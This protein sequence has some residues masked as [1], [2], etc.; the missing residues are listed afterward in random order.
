MTIL[1]GKA[2]WLVAF[3]LFAGQ[4][5]AQ[6]QTSNLAF[7]VANM[8]EDL[9][10]L[11]EAIRSMRVELDNMRRE[12]GQLREQVSG[13]ETRIGNSMGQL[14]TIGQVNEAV[15]KAVTALELRDER[16]KNEI[17]LKV[18]QEITEFANSVK[19]SIGGM[20]EASAK[21]DPTLRKSFPK[22]FPD[23]GTPYVVRAGDTLSSIAKTFGSSVDWIQ[24]ANKIA[25]PRHLQA[26]RTLFIPHN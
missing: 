7:Q 22:N 15:A 20:P 12:N 10:I 16:M 4:G 13:Y 14:A 9:R 19:K 23:T 11:D 24:N 8:G 17:I 18:N 5:F 3:C 2:V 1:R 21:P 26:G 6:T 25:S